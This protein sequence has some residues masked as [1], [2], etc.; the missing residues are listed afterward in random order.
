MDTLY[1][2]NCGGEFPAEKCKTLSEIKHLWDRLT[3]GDPTPSGECPECNCF[4]YGTPYWKSASQPKMVAALLAAAEALDA[5][6]SDLG[7]IQLD[8]AERAKQ[9]EFLADRAMEAREAARTEAVPG[10]VVETR[11]YVL[12]EDG[13]P[14]FFFTGDGDQE[15]PEQSALMYQ[16]DE[17]N[18]PLVEITL[19]ETK[20]TPYVPEPYDDGD[21]EAAS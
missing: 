3:P 17:P 15:S 7:E 2:D 5:A 13:K 9:A 18:V 1:C 4:V 6:A 20:R 10:L 16:E 8:E 11:I 14:E 21:A 12:G 19:T